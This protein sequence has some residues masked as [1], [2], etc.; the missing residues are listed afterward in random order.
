MLDAV[1]CIDS[2]YGSTMWLYVEEAVEMAAYLPILSYPLL[3]A[4]ALLLIGP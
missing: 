3:I 2:E 4:A 1:V